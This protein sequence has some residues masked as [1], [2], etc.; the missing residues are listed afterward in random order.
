MGIAHRIPLFLI[1]F[2]IGSCSAVRV[3]QDFDETA[4]FS[5]YQTF[6]WAPGPPQ[7]SN[8]ILMDSQLMD[9]R[10]RRA[11][12]EVLSAK[13]L[14]HTPGEKP[15]FYVTY[16]NVVQTRLEADSFNRGFGWYGYRYPYWGYPYPF[17]GGIDTYVRQYDE[18]TL[19]IDFTDTHTKELLWRGIGS[20]RV[21]KHSNPEKTTAAVNETVAQILAQYPPMLK[22]EQK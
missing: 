16:H 21:T 20:R 1:L 19:I 3:S 5:R 11:V 22:P 8:D 14:S 10:I 18:G 6:D 17:W 15:D 4:D 2:V 13:G 12:E 7:S 9:R